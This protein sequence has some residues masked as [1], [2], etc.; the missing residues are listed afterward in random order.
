MTPIRVCAITTDCY[1]EDPLVRRTAEAAASGGYEYHVICS[2]RDGQS[3]YELFNGVHVHRIRIRGQKGRPLGRI[4]ARPL[5]EM[6]VLWSFF[7]LLA[8]W[9]VARLHSKLK[10]D[11]VHVH[12]LP[13]FLVFSALI[14]KILGA[15][16]I[17]EIQDV[18][19]ELMAAKA[20]GVFR[21][22][23]VTLT[24]WQERV[25]T[26]FADHVLTVGWPFEQP[27]LKRGVPPEKLSSV[28]NSAD[29]KIFPVEK[30]SDPF[31]GA[32]TAERPII[33]MYHGTFAERHGLDIAMRA[34][35]KARAA[36]PHLRLHLNGGGEE[37]PG[38]KQLAQTLD[39]ADRVTFSPLGPLEKVADFI[40]Q[41]DIGIIPYRSD[42]FMD[43]VLPTKSYEFAWMHRP[44]IASNTLAIRSLFRPGSVRLC[45]PS[46][47]DGFA[48]AILELYRDP[49]KRAQLVADAAQDYEQYRWEIMAERYCHLLASL[50][51]KGAQRK[52][53]RTALTRRELQTKRMLR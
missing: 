47:V 7:G 18:T 37:L 2:M 41:G 4:S 32:A 48:E 5:G 27:L 49:Q 17:L 26:I 42:G 20:K 51:R 22:I 9:R 25:S 35:A 6:L 46:D 16:I 33:L 28:L 8:F 15:Q 19:P 34:F 21:R 44:M 39:V 43:M 38:L 52:G 23:T 45:E 40:V 12:N 1:P 50:A 10:F 24:K 13:D 3:K 14:P 30:R 11:V 29:P 36:A 53:L 31:L